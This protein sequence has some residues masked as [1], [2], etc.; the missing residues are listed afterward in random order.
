MGRGQGAEDGGVLVLFSQDGLNVSPLTKAT[1]NP[2]QN[3]GLWP[4]YL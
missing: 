3:M 1:V 4:L 2:G